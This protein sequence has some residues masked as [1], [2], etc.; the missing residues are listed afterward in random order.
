MVP[1]FSVNT[2]AGCATLSIAFRDL[3]TGNP[4]FWNWDFG[5]GT[6]SNAQNPVV[7]Y[8]QAGTYTVTL[9]VRNADGTTGITKTNL[10]TVY[11]SPTA[12]FSANTTIGCIPVN[13][14]FTDKSTSTSGGIVSWKWDF[15]D[16]GTST[17][18]NPVHTYLNTGF[19][20]V[21]LT[22][23]SSTGCQSTINLVR[24]IRIV[25]GVKAEFDNSKPVSCQ[26]PYA[27]N[28]TNQSSGPGNMTFQWNL[29][30]GNTSTQSAPAT[31]Y[32]A[33]G[34]YNVT[35]T[36]TSE[37]GCSGTITKPV[38]LGGPTTQINVPDSVCQNAKV[39]FVN[40]AS[41]APQ[42]TVWDFG[43]GQQSTN[44][45]DSAL[46]PTPGNYTVKLFNTYSSCKDSAVK[47]VYVRP[48]PM[49][50]FTVAN[51]AACKPPLN[52]TFQD[53]SPAPITKWIWDFGDGSTGTGSTTTH[54]YNSAGN[55]NVSVVFTDNKGCEG[56]IT[57]PAVIQIVPP[58]VKITSVP[59][60]G[61]IPYN[62][63]PTANVTSVDGIATYS[64][65]FGD[66]TIITG[67]NPSPPHTYANTG[68]YDIKLTIT[69]NGGCTA[70]TTEAGGVKT[71]KPPAT[72]FSM[73][74]TDVCASQAINFTDLTPAPVDEWLWE[75]GDG[76]TSD[77]PNPSHTYSDSG[78]FTVKLTAFNNRCPSV[79]TGQL[80]HIKPPIAKFDY[81]TTCGNLTVSFINQSK[82]DPNPLLPVSYSWQFGNPVLPGGTSNLPSPSFLFPG[83]NFYPVTL[84]V[85]QGGCI[86][87]YTDTVKLVK[88]LANFTVAPIVCRN[89][90]FNITSTNSPQLIAKYEWSIDGGPFTT[91]SATYVANI[92]TRGLHSIGLTITDINGCPDTKVVAD[93][94]T[95]TAPFANFTAASP[96]GC[97]NDII[98]FN[99]HSTLGSTASPL[100]KW[101]FDFNDGKTQSFTSTSYTHTYTD[102]GEFVPQLTIEDAMGCTD[103][104]KLPDTIFISSPKTSF[105]SDY[106]TICPSSDIHF[107]D[108]STGK[109]LTYLWDFGNG[110]S[111]S[112]A[113]DPVFS[114]GGNNATYTVKLVI[115]DRG[116]CKDSVTRTNYITTIKPIPAFDILDTLTICPPIE[117]K[118]TFQGSNYESFEWDFGDGATSTLKDPTHFY[119]AYGDF[120]AKLY[121]YGYGGC[122]DSTSKFVHVVNPGSKTILTYSP[123]DACNELTVNFSVTPIPDI[124]YALYFG[125]GTVDSIMA[126]T[127][128]HFY[129]S[130]AFYGPAIVYTDKQ[131]CISGVDGPVIKVIGADPFFGVDKKKFCDSGTVY[132]TNYT[133]GNDPVVSRT[134]DFGDG[135]PTTSNTDP[136]HQY[137]QPGLYSVSQSVTTQQ[138]CSKTI[139]DTIRVY[140]TPDPYI[141][142]DSIGCLNA[143]LNLQ[144]MLTVPDT[145]IT[146]KWNLGNNN[147]PTTQNVSMNFLNSGN[148]TVKLEA[149]NSFGCT[150][151]TSKNLFVPPIPTLTVIDNP[152]IPVSTGIILPVTYGPE[153][154]KYTWTPAKNLS[155]TDCPTPY[156]N[157]RSTTTYTVKVTD[158]YGCTNTSNV[159]V[160]VV[161]NGLNYFIPNTFSPNGDGVNDVF[162][163]RG[164]G[165]ARVN[166]M[167]IFNRWGEMVFERMNFMANDR[168]PTGGW[169]G[170]YKGKPASADVYVYIIEFVC[171]NSVIVP[172]KGNVALVR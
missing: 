52:V 109:G 161:C 63:I 55:F 73:S 66:G 119:N 19:Y 88:E 4:K 114:Y 14:Q 95:V 144:G 164:V 141:A 27:I 21:S 160:T 149:S 74:A 123:L 78:T 65:D 108:A 56:K 2:T 172:V 43:N 93:V 81:S 117:T 57:K 162:A 134:W 100:T 102:T 36:A 159:T 39:F 70:T 72:N 120:T 60:G 96:G 132:F 34:T 112:T 111:T 116:G 71:G 9:V 99:D 143:T 54:L 37:F 20:N 163:P 12:N 137:Q 158:Q 105:E 58:T 91:G 35:L 8:T 156:A 90:N 59:A 136:A 121:I 1:D 3:T 33:T 50:D 16:G 151:T 31:T 83:Y 68:V 15:G 62:Y 106:T 38:T 42:K 147:S 10:I 126:T 145:A 5:N 157:P 122:I 47:V 124:K 28:F 32:A 77:L 7:N 48:S 51:A 29:G 139:S 125:D 97:K 53:A 101:T 129:K 44:T 127:Y 104:Y 94:V 107:A 152:V 130:P 153:V 61:C 146:W 138:G 89:A 11:P 135:S 165:L 13:I 49:I 98:T 118:F 169:D 79:S 76:S 148:Y 67:I 92:A 82:T 69:T 24:Y 26:A 6:L 85:T 18:Q 133:I 167:R 30:N 154:V 75:F 22:V 41:V 113:K 87:T 64:W 115:T 168:T 45:N 46:Y 155:C 110:G 80:V 131:G 140:R 23:T 142:G 103:T 84:T 171:E 166:S 170:T 150:D 40:N 128:Q 25:S 86:N 17:A